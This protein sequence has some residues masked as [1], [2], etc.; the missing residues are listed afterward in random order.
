MG[1]LTHHA[2]ARGGGGVSPT[3]PFCL[4]WGRDAQ[5][6]LGVGDAS[7][8]PALA[9]DLFHYLLQLHPGLTRAI[10]FLD[11]ITPSPALMNSTQCVVSHHSLGVF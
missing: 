7:L 9:W 6:R 10:A 8:W 3:P 5:R 11:I 4:C 1:W 2:R